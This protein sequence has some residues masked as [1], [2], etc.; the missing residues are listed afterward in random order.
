MV[1][2]GQGRELNAILGETSRN[3]LLFGLLLAIGLCL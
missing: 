1:Q 2:I 3:M